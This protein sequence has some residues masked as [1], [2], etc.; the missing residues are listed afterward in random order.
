MMSFTF[1]LKK[2]LQYYYISAKSNYNLKKPS[3]TF[4]GNLHGIQI[5]TLSSLLHLLH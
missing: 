4:P 1:Y 2:N 5:H 3:S